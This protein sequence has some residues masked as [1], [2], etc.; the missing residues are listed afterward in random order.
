[1]K[2]SL[3]IILV[4]LGGLVLFPLLAYAETGQPDAGKAPISQPLVREG[5]LAVKLV[6]ALKLGPAANEAEAE[7]L[8]A[9][10]GIAPRNGWMA[11]YPVTPDIMD[12]LQSAVSDAA[13]AKQLSMGKDEAMRAFQDVMVSYNLSIRPA[14]GSGEPG[15]TYSSP[16][17]TVINNYYYDEGPPVVTYYAPPP[18]FYYL[19]SWVPYPFWWWDSWFP[20][21][22][23]LADFDIDIGGHHHHHHRHGEHGEFVTNHFRDPSTGRMSR[24]DPA[25]RTTG[26]TFSR[27]SGMVTHA[28]NGGQAILDRSRGFAPSGRSAMTGTG[29]PT[30]SPVQN[31]RVSSPSGVW[32]RTSGAPSGRTSGS[33]SINRGTAFSPSGGRTFNTA[34]AGRQAF[35]PA[36]RSSGFSNTFTSRPSVSRSYSMP[37]GGGNTFRG[38]SGFYSGGRSFSS[39]PSA[40]RSF[41]MPSRGGGT[42][43]GSSGMGRT[44]GSFGGGS[45]GS[46]GGWHR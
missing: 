3:F 8:L 13:D 14:E 44:S 19:Y 5:T 31:S 22:F 36:P 43:R 4:I 21:F 25:S 15:S 33:T 16:D 20:G 18:D 40:S 2:S 29:S 23:V 28:G 37:S 30:G 42:F 11:D 1:M 17:S 26:G 27:G 35:T 34:P 10:A 6:D 7:G 9:G 24:I 38:S 32:G 46:F 45:R 12:E 39:P 41:S